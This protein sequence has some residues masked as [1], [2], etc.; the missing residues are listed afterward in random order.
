MNK[1]N[2]QPPITVRTCGNRLS[3]R[4][5]ST[6][7]LSRWRQERL[8]AVW[9][10]VET[11]KTV[12]L[13][14]IMG[15]TEPDSGSVRIH[16]R[17]VTSIDS[18]ALREIRKRIGFLCQQASLYDSLTVQEN[19]AF[20]LARH[21]KL[22]E[23]ECKSKARAA[24]QCGDGQRLARLTDLA[25]HAKARRLG[26]LWLWTPRFCSL[27]SLLRVSIRSPQGDR[28]TD[29]GPKSEAPDDRRGGDTRY[30]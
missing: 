25:R 9:D 17:K 30:P 14:L 10:S 28:Q 15:F 27:T 16:G 13:K 26:A 18:G 19:V 4:E 22:P 20:P 8:R 21:T 5:P 6:G 23:P 1:A 12:L 2:H 29:S 24:R 3:S 7:S 11:G